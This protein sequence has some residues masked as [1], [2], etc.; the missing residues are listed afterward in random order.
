MLVLIPFG[1]KL[2]EKIDVLTKTHTCDLVDLR[3]GKTIVRCKWVYKIETKSYSTVESCKGCLVA[4]EFNQEY[5]IAFEETFALV[6]RF[7]YVRSLL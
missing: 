4:M 6:A 7:T 3:L 2:S 5:G 1:K